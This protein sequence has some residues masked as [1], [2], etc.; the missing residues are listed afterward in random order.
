MNYFELFE[1][2]EWPVVDKSILAKKYFELQKQNHPD[3]FTLGTE[4]ERETSLERSAAINKAFQ[5]F[6]NDQKTLEYYLVLTGTILPGEK[7]TL[8]PEFLM[9]MMD[10]NEELAELDN[11]QINARVGELEALFY[12]DV[13]PVFNQ[14]AGTA[15]LKEDLEKLREYYYKKKYVE[16]I[17]DRLDD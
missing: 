1:F 15:L 10:V 8:P 9:E 12:K 3:Y 6:S 4:E 13:A 5:V 7:Y 16:R 2:P 17:L 14:V 11:T